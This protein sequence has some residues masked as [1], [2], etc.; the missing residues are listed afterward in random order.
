MNA[1]AIVAASLLVA[2]CS[3][4]ALNVGSDANRDGGDVD[5]GVVGDGA[6]GDAKN[7]GDGQLPPPDAPAC[8]PEAVWRLADD[9]FSY[10]IFDTP[11]LP[12]FPTCGALGRTYTF[13]T[14]SKSL[15]LHE[16]SADAGATDRDVPL[17]DA[18]ASQVVTSLAALKTACPVEACVADGGGQTLTVTSSGASR[19]YEGLKVVCFAPG[20]QFVN[21]GAFDAV[22]RALV[23]G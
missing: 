11:L 21:L 8:A 16:C 1:K 15:H 9:G 5:A 18:Q 22:L 4:S 10:L 13:T 7:T 3:S 2:A 17:T 20:R 6:P 14:S 12:P 23:G 19:Y